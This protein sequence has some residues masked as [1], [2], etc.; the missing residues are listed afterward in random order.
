[1]SACGIGHKS[2][3]MASVVSMLRC[4]P[5]GRPVGRPYQGRLRDRYSVKLSEGHKLT[6]MSNLSLE[7]N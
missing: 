2:P 4:F 5:H 6:P 7:G 1:M 3:E